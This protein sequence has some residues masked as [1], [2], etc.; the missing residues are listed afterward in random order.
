MGFNIEYKVRTH[1][2]HL[3]CGKKPDLSNSDLTPHSRIVR[4][5]VPLY[6]AYYA[7]Q[8]PFPDLAVARRHCASILATQVSLAYNTYSPSSSNIGNQTDFTCPRPDSSLINKRNI[9]LSI[10]LCLHSLKCIRS[11]HF[12]NIHNFWRSN[13]Q[14]VRLMPHLEG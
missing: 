5:Q 11:F 8:I 1:Q 12:S 6:D 2:H 9:S 14:R 4:D 7:V 10:L 13:N 3:E